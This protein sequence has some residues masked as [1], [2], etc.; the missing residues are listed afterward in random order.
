[1]RTATEALEVN[2]IPLRKGEG[3]ICGLAAANRDPRH[4]DD[5]DQLRLE[6]GTPSHLAF[7][8]GMH[9]CI[10]APLARLDSLT[11]ALGPAGTRAD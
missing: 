7:V 3:V 9:H 8:A 11:V 1:M 4:I 5:P 2:G 10:G 6:R